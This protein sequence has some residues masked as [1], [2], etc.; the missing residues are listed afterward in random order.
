MPDSAA[1]A[2][3]DGLVPRGPRHL[4]ELERASMAMAEVND[5]H[6]APDRVHA[7]ED[8]VAAAEQCHETR[9]AYLAASCAL[10]DLGARGDPQ[11]GGIELVL[12]QVGSGGSVLRPPIGGLVRLG[13]EFRCE[14]QLV[15]PL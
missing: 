11:E 4:P 3:A 13:L 14:R 15:W 12:E 8:Q 10:A 1:A 7:I 5:L 9:I 6:L 2:L